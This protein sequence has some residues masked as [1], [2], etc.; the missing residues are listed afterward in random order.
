MSGKRG[1]F[2]EI[3]FILNLSCD[4]ISGKTYYIPELYSNSVVNSIDVDI[5]PDKTLIQKLGLIGYRTEQAIAELIDNS[6]DARIEKTPEIIEVI[7]SFENRKIT[8][9]D[10]GIGMDKEDLT[11]AMTIAKGTKVDGKLGKFGI[12]MK[13]ACSALGKNF[14]II[15]SKKDSTKEYSIV[16][17]EDE[18]LSDK[19]QTWDNFRITEH[20]QEKDRKW[21][22]TKIVISKL[23]VPLYSNQ[24][25]N[26]NESFGI[27]YAPYILDGQIHLRINTTICKPQEPEIVPGTRKNVHITLLDGSII[28]GYVAL[29]KKRSIKG[30]YGIHLF[31]NGRLIKAYEKFGFKPHPEIAKIIGKLDLDYVPVNFHKSAFIEDSPEYESA[32]KAFANDVKVQQILK[33]S[34][35]RNEIQVT[36][37]T[38]FRY[39]AGEAS[40]SYLDT[41]I[42]TK[43]GKQLLDETKEFTLKLGNNK[44][45]VS[46]VDSTIN[47]L[48]DVK[49]VEDKLQVSI[50]RNNPMFNY[51]RNPL[52]LIGLIATEIELISKDPKSYDDFIKPRNSRFMTFIDD[53]RKKEPISRERQEQLPQFAGYTLSDD[54]ATIHNELKNKSENKFQFTALSTLAN[55]LHYSMGK[56]IYTVYTMPGAGMYLTDLLSQIVP[57]NFTV[58]DNPEPNELTLV[59][60]TSRSDKIII[61]R[62]YAEIYGSTI[63]APERAWVDL[64]NEIY[65]HKIPVQ[66]TELKYIFEGLLARKIVDPNKISILLKHQK[67]LEKV[68]TIIEKVL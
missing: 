20:E 34:R 52:F 4:I 33:E 53:W 23:K 6:I 39:I 56:K 16:Y 24:V 15:T 63:A 37:N 22:G 68:R 47:S 3:I 27:R 1:Y 61:V 29:L 66:E 49:W 12:G 55:Y 58:L 10:N 19:S 5:T 35:T 40:P 31:K 60:D 42:T 65:T 14:T 36:P 64:V 28:K 59:L 51:V 8:V 2:P 48:Y 62:E 21:H 30:H 32:E 26:F 57:E 43:V 13:S 38:V 9:S 54:L 45:Y 67:K 7:L 25:A 11:N 44:T 18:W 17:D 46:F 50:N 41:R